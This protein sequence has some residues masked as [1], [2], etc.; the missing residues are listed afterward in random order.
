MDTKL[1]NLLTL[2]EL[3]AL[4]GLGLTGFLTLDHTRVTHQETFL[5]ES[6][7]ILDV[8]LA[9]SAGD[10]HTKSLSLTG[11]STTVEVGLDVP[12]AFSTSNQERLVDD[13]LQRTGGEILFIVAAV[14]LD[15]A[16]A[17]FHVYAGDGG[18]SS[19]YCINNFCH[20]AYLMSLML[21]T[22]GF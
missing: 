15:F 22:L 21:M 17:G 16:V 2:A 4:T 3:E 14:D 20:N 1:A 5:L 7:A 10:S 8:V 19:T 13:V 9:K 18:L 11:D 12:L 6:G